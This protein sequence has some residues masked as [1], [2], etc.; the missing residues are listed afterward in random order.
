[1][2][3]YLLSIFALLIVG[4]G[5]RHQ[6]QAERVDETLSSSIVQ[7][8]SIKKIPPITVEHIREEIAQNPL[9]SQSYVDSLEIDLLDAIKGDFNGNG[10]ID[11]AYSYCVDEVSE[12]EMLDGFGGIIF[13]DSTIQEITNPW[14]ICFLLNEGDL[15]GDGA[16]EL[17]FY[18]RGTMS[19][20]G[21]YSVWSFRNG[22]WYALASVA[23][24]SN[25]D[26]YLQDN[27]DRND[28]VR[29]DPNRQ[30][31]LLIRELEMEDGD[32][33]RRVEKSVKIE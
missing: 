9:L 17:G 4:C 23:Y 5:N 27:F 13:S 1:M 24:N 7:V 32:W 11:I 31:Y 22:Q 33:V 3:T 18:A 21:T 12:N 20:W 29:I 30:G 26:D 14:L 6:Q 19:G 2:K 8:D 16:D 15:D 10:K 25:F 28:L